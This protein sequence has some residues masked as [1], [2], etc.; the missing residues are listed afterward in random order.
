M[1]QW[2]GHQRFQTVP[3]HHST[4]YTLAMSEKLFDILIQGC[5]VSP[6]TT[7]PFCHETLKQPNRQFWSDESHAYQTT[8]QPWVWCKGTVTLNLVTNSASFPSLRTVCA[9]H[10]GSFF[11]TTL[12]P[13]HTLHSIVNTMKSFAKILSASF[14]TFRQWDGVSTDFCLTRALLAPKEFTSWVGMRPY[15]STSISFLNN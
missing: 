12:S 5:P 7:W 3:R 14:V 6:P 1:F 8:G 4:Q 9:N 15:R 10:Q 11:Q 13:L 2:Q